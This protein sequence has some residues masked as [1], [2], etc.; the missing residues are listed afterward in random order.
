MS[1]PRFWKLILH[2]DALKKFS[3]EKG[4]LLTQKPAGGAISR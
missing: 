1:E 4:E 3:I 2:Q